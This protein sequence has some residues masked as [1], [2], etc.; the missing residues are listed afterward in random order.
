MKN[1]LW[2]DDFYDLVKVLEF[3]A[4]KH[5]AHNWLQ[6][7]GK[8]SSHSE[9]CDSMFHHLAEAY[10]GHTKDHESGLHPLLHLACRAMMCYVIQKHD[11]RGENSNE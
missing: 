11:I 7:N 5:G 10:A 2:H 6:P 9:M 1:D 8:K 3:G 4:K